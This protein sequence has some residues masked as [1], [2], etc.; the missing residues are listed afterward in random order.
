MS[1]RPQLKDIYSK[2]ASD[3]F[4]GRLSA[5]GRLEGDFVKKNKQ[6]KKTK[7][8][9][10]SARV[11]TFIFKRSYCGGATP[12]F[13]YSGPKKGREV[14][15]KGSNLHVAGEMAEMSHKT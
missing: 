1:R 12:C 13:H 4:L 14:S 3:P 6:T 9:S 5:T 8:E 10:V 7:T 2:N 15:S 11:E